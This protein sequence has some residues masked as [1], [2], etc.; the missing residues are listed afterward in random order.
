MLYHPLGGSKISLS[1]EQVT[2]V[3]GPNGN[4]DW[5]NCG[6]N[7]NGGWQPPQVEVKDLVFVNLATSVKDNNSVFQP[8]SPYVS[9]FE[10]YGAQF[11]GMSAAD[12]LT[13]KF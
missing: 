10:K 1:S 12:L 2:A 5:L 7:D 6:I 3:S 9:L 8:C 4:I 13:S 11:S